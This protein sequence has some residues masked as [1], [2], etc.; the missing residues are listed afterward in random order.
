V[1]PVNQFETFCKGK[2]LVAQIIAS[3]RQKYPPGSLMATIA[4]MTRRGGVS[5]RA[6][7][8]KRAGLGTKSRG[9]QR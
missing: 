2:I 5:I 9:N 8:E 3:D 4:E 1:N 6:E 7:L